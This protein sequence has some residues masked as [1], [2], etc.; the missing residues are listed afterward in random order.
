M[1]VV[2][3]TGGVGS[4]KSTVSFLLHEMTE[5]VLL[6]AD[7]IGKLMMKK[8]SSCF[9]EIIKEFGKGIIDKETGE[10]DRNALST[11]IFS[12]AEKKEKLEAIV[13][14]AVKKYIEDTIENNKDKKG[15]IIFE[16]AI[17]FDTNTDKYCDEIWFVD[18]DLETRKKRLKENRGYSDEK[19][20]SILKA[21]KTDYAKEHSDVV[22]SNNGHK[23]ELREVIKNLIKERN[24]T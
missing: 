22:I 6:I 10:L 16:S 5:S 24:L 3:I 15:I 12:S 2:G 13:H 4:G 14:P 20:E 9:D 23:D 1:K 7:D 17:I 19:T 8:G 11:S 21:Q 18:V